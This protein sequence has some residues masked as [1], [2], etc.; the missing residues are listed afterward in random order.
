MR[1]PAQLILTPLN[2]QLQHPHLAEFSEIDMETVEVAMG[3]CHFA[4][5]LGNHLRPTY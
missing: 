2:L 3:L 1:S 4:F 5:R